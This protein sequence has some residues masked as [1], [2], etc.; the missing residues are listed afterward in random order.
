MSI[1]KILHEKE[2]PADAKLNRVAEVVSAA[3]Q[4]YGNEAN[5]I[6]SPMVNTSNGTMSFVHL[7]EDSKVAYLKGEVASL[8]AKAVEYHES[9]PGTNLN[10]KIEELV[11]TNGAFCNIAAGTKFEYI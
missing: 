3:R 8:K 5:E 11:A 9:H 7:D 10:K 1:T 2:T 4:A 6:A